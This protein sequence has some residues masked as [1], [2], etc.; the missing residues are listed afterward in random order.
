[1]EC[2]HLFFKGPGILS[3]QCLLHSITH[4]EH[5][6]TVAVMFISA[7]PL[8]VS[9]WITKTGINWGLLFPSSVYLQL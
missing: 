8:S 3:S 2:K 4:M 1:M 6:C 5:T 7:F 9:L